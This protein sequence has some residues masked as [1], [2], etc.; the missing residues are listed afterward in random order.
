MSFEDGA[1]LANWDLS[2]LR[3]DSRLRDSKSEESG[4][5]VG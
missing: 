3:Q 2:K 5:E 1:S 4:A